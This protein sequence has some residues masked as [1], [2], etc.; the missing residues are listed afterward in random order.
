VLATSLTV[1]AFA[2]GG[3][4][5]PALLLVTAIL[6]GAAAGV[7]RRSVRLAV[8]VSL[9]VLVS[10]V[11]VSVLTR[12]GDTVLV[13]LGPFDV[14]AEGLDFAARISL[15]LFV[16]ALAV[17]V[18]GLTTDVRSLVADLERRGVSPRITFA[19][20]AERD[21]VPAMLQ[22]AR[23]VAAA[24]RARGLDTEGSVGARLRG[25]RPLVG[26]VLL[27]AIAEVDARSLALE[28]R[29]FG[30]TGKRHPLWTP[31]DSNAQRLARW[32]MVAGV[33]VLLALR[34]SGPLAWVP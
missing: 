30:Q 6:A 10:V 14:T 24:Q 7:L 8:L 13:V 5:V 2:H 11:L 15:R 28:A 21:A 32:G 19:A 17:T 27:S 34:A 9:P 12:A 31:A 16:G 18:F 1:A 26:P 20:A 22:R 33:I 29:A 25:V 3:Y 23:D 4:A